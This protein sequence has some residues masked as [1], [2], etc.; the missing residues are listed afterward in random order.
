M[1]RVRLDV[2]DAV[3]SVNG[4]VK[5]QPLSF[6]IDWFG[7]SDKGKKAHLEDRR[8]AVPDLSTK[9][10]HAFTAENTCRLFCI[11]DGHG[12]SAV[13]SYCQ[14]NVA[15][16]VAEKLGESMEG[17]A[18]VDV[19]R[20][21]HSAFKECDRRILSWLGP[22]KSEGATCTVVYFQNDV[23][24]TGNIGDSKAVLGRVSRET[25][26]EKE[27]DDEEVKALLLTQDHTVLQ[28]SE[29]RRIESRHG[30]IVNGR[31]NGIL[32]VTRSFGDPEMKRI[33]VS[34]AP[35][36]SRFRV[37]ERDKFLI[38]ACDGL[39]SV[40]SMSD[41]V[42]FVHCKLNHISKPSVE[43][44]TRMLLADAILN[45]QAKDNVSAIIIRFDHHS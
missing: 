37:C 24:W 19:Q 36:I 38:I 5:F 11:I 30:S 40:F 7:G 23:V 8:I 3:T 39:W 34:A 1:K 28:L 41:A 25:A 17:E 26:E 31:V 4:D 16:I 21:L 27:W 10:K 14:S 20:A 29:V 42:E 33:G 9:W 15:S 22:L 12:G 43:E 35:Y 6:S 2:P 13:S 18:G 44:V 32:E 45:K